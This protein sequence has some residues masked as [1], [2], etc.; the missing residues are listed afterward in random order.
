[1]TA[2]GAT[3]RRAGAANH[4]TLALLLGACWFVAA[5]ATTA[6][7]EPRPGALGSADQTAA[8]PVGDLDEGGNESARDAAEAESLQFA[9]AILERKGG[10]KLDAGQREGVARALVSA[11]SEHG[12]SVVLALAMIELESGFDPHAKGPAG[13][14]GLMQL[15]PATARAVARRHGFDWKNSHTLLDPETNARLGLAY[16]AELRS[17]FGTTDH[18]IAA[19]NIGPGNL[20]R[21]LARHPLRRGPYLTKVYA[22]VDALREQYPD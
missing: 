10:R 4:L 8:V 12:I 17:R 5:C 18:A 3:S 2:L 13:S 16:L 15:Q 21:L 19:Y 1:M 11:E 7:V 6:P 20:R 22:H 9:R 14:I